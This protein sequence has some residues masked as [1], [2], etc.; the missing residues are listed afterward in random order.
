MINILIGYTL[1]TFEFFLRKTT[2]ETN[3]NLDLI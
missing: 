1:F 2:L 3:L